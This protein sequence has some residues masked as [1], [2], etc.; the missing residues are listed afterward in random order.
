M[1]AVA[2]SLFNGQGIYG[3]S[4][5]IADAIDNGLK[6]TVIKKEAVQRWPMLTKLVQQSRQIAGQVHNSEAHYELLVPVQSI[7]RRFKPRH[8]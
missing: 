4:I 2:W 5:E 6:W 8:R 1:S 3:P 7:G